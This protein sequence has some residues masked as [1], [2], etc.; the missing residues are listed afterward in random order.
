MLCES[1]RYWNGT[2]FKK[3]Q[4]DLIQYKNTAN[5]V[6]LMG[7]FNARTSNLIDYID[8][9]GV[10]LIVPRFDMDKNQKQW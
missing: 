9:D 5:K 8:I 3:K 4:E 2:D 6:I 7:D 10:T 1:S